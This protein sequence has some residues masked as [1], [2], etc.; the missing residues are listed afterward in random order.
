MPFLFQYR[1]V[2]MLVVHVHVHVK[3]EFVE[4]FRQATVENARQSLN[5]PGIARFD[6]LEQ[7]SDPARFVLTEV[8]RTAGAAAAHKATAH[9]QVWRDTVAEMMAEPRASMQFTNVFP[10]EAW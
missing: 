10:E 1:L 2:N 4:R 3:P 5:E 6:V 7:A 9:Y 8:Y